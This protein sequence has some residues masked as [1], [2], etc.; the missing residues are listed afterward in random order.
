LLT[1]GVSMPGPART[2]VEEALAADQ[3]GRFSRNEL[4]VILGRSAAASGQFDV[5]SAE[6]LMFLEETG[7]RHPFAERIYLRPIDSLAPLDL[8][9]AGV[10]HTSEGP[11]YHPVWRTGVPVSKERLGQAAAACLYAAEQAE[12]A[13][14]KCRALFRLGWIQRALNDWEK[15]A[16]A[17]E[18][19]AAEAA[20]M[21]LA[22]DAAWL[23]VENLVW[24]DRPAEAADR[25]RR[26][27]RAYP[28]DA[29]TRGAAIRLELLETEAQRGEAMLPASNRRLSV[30]GRRN[31]QW[32]WVLAGSLDR[33]LQRPIPLFCRIFQANTRPPAP[34]AARGPWR[35]A[36]AVTEGSSMR[37]P[38]QRSEAKARCTSEEDCQVPAA[39]AVATDPATPA[40]HSMYG[41]RL[42]NRRHIRSVALCAKKE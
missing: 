27:V 5:S 34:I 22:A 15:S 41:V 28:N 25:L 1:V 29:R 3:S 30:R 12:Q 21:H 7:P 17:W 39:R 42:S 11:R 40:R 33:V 26:F 36:S 35:L 9:S 31:A 14:V 32:R 37:N 2:I 4:L 23:T 10:P 13:Q 8:K 38:H 18:P 20:G 6:Y 24:T 16:R 19:C